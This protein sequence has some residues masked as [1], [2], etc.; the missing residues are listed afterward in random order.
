MS[1]TEVFATAYAIIFGLGV[2]VILTATIEAFRHRAKTRLH[3]V[4]F[5]WVPSPL[6]APFGWG[7]AV[8]SAEVFVV[9]LSRYG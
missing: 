4:P 2:M 5:V 7:M 6:G 1:V 3:W 8:D 9:G